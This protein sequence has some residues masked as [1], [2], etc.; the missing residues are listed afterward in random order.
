MNKYLLFSLLF[1][2]S[3]NQVSEDFDTTNY[4][5]EFAIP[6]ITDASV[7]F[8]ELWENNS[9]EG[10]S[11]VV[12]ADG[13]LVFK[14][15]SEPVA[16]TTLDVIGAL[17]FPI[18][19]GLTDT[20]SALPFTL[21]ANIVLQKATL[22]SGTLIFQFRP[23]NDQLVDITFILPHITLDG[24]PLAIQTDGTTGRTPMIDLAGYT[25]E[26]AGNELEIKY[27][28]IDEEGNQMTLEGAGVI[29]RPVLQF[30]S[31]TWGREEFQLPSATVPIDLYDERF[32]NGNLRFSQPTITANI[33]SSFGVPI[34]SRVDVLSAQT[35]TGW[36][37]DIDASAIDGVDIN[38]PLL[39]DRGQRKKTTLQI[40]Y[41]NSNI[42]E[43][44]DT[45]PTQLEYGLTA[46]ANPD[47]DESLTVFI[48]DTSTFKAEVIVEVP[49][50]GRV[51][52]FTATENFEV[53][54]EDIDAISEG[55]F[56]LIVENELPIGA[57]LQFYFIK[58]NKQII[59]SLFQEI[60][61]LVEPAVIDETGNVT[62]SIETTTFIPIAATKMATIIEANQVL[63]KATFQTAGNGVQ[64]VTVKAGQTI[65]FRMGL[66]FKL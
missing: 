33:E 63:V 61:Q 36:K 59:D 22:A 52:N 60:S 37:M 16:V 38:Y 13:V 55:E 56:K 14:Y 34:R 20:V 31:G 40:D 29:A 19:A 1:L 65:N 9:L 32:L 41:T 2:V 10:Q 3:C 15:E 57:A 42:V 28:A 12:G 35:K 26:P 66:R 44:F 45:Q 39:A 5:P 6:V 51:A 47:N 27:Q 17:D 53:P 7:S 8:T 50:V 46:I 58:G 64:D 30:V 25:F 54:F 24:V 48:E 23:I 49:V 62:Q 11:L 21:P 43:V 18:V 4:A